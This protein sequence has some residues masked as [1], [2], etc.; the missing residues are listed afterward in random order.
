MSILRI[1]PLSVTVSTEA[2]DRE[3]VV[4]VPRGPG[5]NCLKEVFPG[6]SFIQSETLGMSETTSRSV[7]HL[8]NTRLLLN[9]CF[10]LV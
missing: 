8:L 4:E 7:I 3:G 9:K 1:N 5:P 2:S 10:C 6:L